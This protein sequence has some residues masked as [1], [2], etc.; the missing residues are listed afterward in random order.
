MSEKNKTLVSGI[1]CIILGVL[2]AIFGG[3]EVLDIY[4]GVVAVV[5]GVCLLVLSIYT[6]C[7][8]LPVPVPSFIM[9]CVLTAV[10]ITLFTEYL[11]VGY[12]INFLVVIILGA[13]AGI[14][15][16]GIYLLTKKEVAPG[17]MNLALGIFAIVVAVLYIA[18][19]DFRSV[20]WIIVGVLIAVY[21]LVDVVLGIK[22]L[23]SKK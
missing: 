23:Q 2:I 11:T 14:L 21:G 16:L 8:K 19:P 6:M 17:L 1:F 4:F 9:G 15:G 7:K 10:G 13:G 5:S 3:Q 18:V 20:F 12:V 22:D